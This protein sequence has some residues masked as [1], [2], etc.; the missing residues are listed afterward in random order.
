MFDRTIVMGL[1]LLVAGIGPG[2]PVSGAQGPAPM[3]TRERE[4][5]DKLDAVMQRLEKVEGEL[6]EMRAGKTAASGE[7]AEA[8]PLEARVADLEKEREGALKAMWKDGLRIES[9][10][11]QFKLQLGGRVWVDYTWFD[12]DRDLADFVFDEEDGGQ[13]RNARLDMRGDI[14]KDVFYRLEYEFAGNNGPSGFTDTYVGLKGIPYVGTLQ[15]GHYKEPFSLEELTNDSTITFMERALPN[16]FAPGRNLG[17]Q[18][19][20]AYLGEAGKERLT[21]ALGVFKSTDNW[22]SANDGDEDQGYALTARVT[23]LPWFDAENKRLFH[24]GLSYSH[25]NP[26]GAVVNPYLIRST[27]E[28]RLLGFRWV[29][30]ESA[31]DGFRLANAIPDNVDLWSLESALVLGPLSLQGEYIRSDVET[32]IGGDLGFDGYYIYASYML[33]GESRPYRN[34]A[35]VFDKIRPKSNFGWGKGWGA[36]ELAARY[37]AIRLSDGPIRG[38]DDRNLTLGL[39]WYLNPNTRWMLNYIMADIDHDLYSGNMNILQT[40]F[41]IDF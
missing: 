29:D 21:Y 2:F 32:L 22:P 37:S 24:L 40:R 12:Q 28:A 14:Y 36:W 11:G 30:S 7:T 8:A 5:L 19:S 6:A 1:V 26:D 10:D 39:N 4:L 3:T 9:P 33:T 41:Q 25:R 18:L 35:G 31:T 15:I 17:A 38:G 20:N 16:A 23:G 27:P 13:I 34:A